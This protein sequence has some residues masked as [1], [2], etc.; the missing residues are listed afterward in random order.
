MLKNKLKLSAMLILVLILGACGGENSGESSS[1][2]GESS[3]DSGSIE[4]LPDQMVW[5]VYD[6]GSGGYIEST[7]IANE[8]TSQYGTQ[9][10]LLPSSGGVGR[11]QPMKNDMADFGRLGDE[12]QFAFEGNDE[13]STEEW[14]PQDV[15][16][17]WAPFSYLGFV[18]LEESGIKTIADLKGKK[19]P[20]ITGNQSVNIKAE[21][22]LAF[23]GLTWDDVVK[24][25]LADYGGQADAMRNGQIDVTFMNPTASVLIELDSMEDIVWIEMD[26]NDTAGW[27]QVQEIAPWVVPS[28]MD[29]GAGMTAENPITLQGYGYPVV[30]YADQSA[31][32][33]YAYVKA[34]DETYEDWEGAAANLHNWHKEN[35]LVEPFGVPVHEGTIKF[36]EEEGLWTE[37]YQ[38]K[39]DALIERAEKLQELWPQVLESAKEEGISAAD[40]SDYWKEQK[41]ELIK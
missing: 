40:F 10:R 25:E 39:N 24:T 30:S 23:A 4:N 8:M 35:I 41:E 29:N 26:E 16:V 7:A 27:D 32:S 2:S 37:E 33:V 12:Y 22:A 18:T 36:L 14:G 21:A 11:M 1:A 34:M 9:I 20:Y 3:G 19:V 28:E 15:R 31:E 17:V 5:S 38:V 6:V 13:F